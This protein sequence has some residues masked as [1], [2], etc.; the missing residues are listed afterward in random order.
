MARQPSVGWACGWL[1]SAVFWS[2]VGKML[3]FPWPFLKRK[4]KCT[5]TLGSRAPATFSESAEFS[6][7]CSIFRREK[8]AEPTRYGYA[9]FKH[10]CNVIIGNVGGRLAWTKACLT[11]TRERPRRE[12]RKSGLKLNFLS[13]PPLFFLFL[14]YLSLS[15]SLSLSCQYSSLL[16]QEKQRRSFSC[17]C[18]LTENKKPFFFTYDFTRSYITRILEYFLR[19]NCMQWST[20][21]SASLR[22]FF[23][24]LWRNAIII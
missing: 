3:W 5:R 7:A 18:L 16:T 17:V 24:N 20:L 23:R 1:V 13:F 10:I 6:C 2:W 19:P 4:M 11:F 14:S 12:K 9:S 22:R 8:F 15:L 21:L